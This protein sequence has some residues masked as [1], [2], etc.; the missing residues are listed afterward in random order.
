MLAARM[1]DGIA[2]KIYTTSPRWGENHPYP[3]QL[4]TPRRIDARRTP[5]PYRRD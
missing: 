4:E 3:D 5:V 2:S 1:D